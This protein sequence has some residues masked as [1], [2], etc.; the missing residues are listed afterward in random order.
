[1]S[2]LIRTIG[3]ISMIALFLTACD[4]KGDKD[5]PKEPK[6]TDT[7]DDT[8]EKFG[9]DV[10]KKLAVLDLPGYKRTVDGQMAAGS[11]GPW[12][13]TNQANPSGI[14]IQAMVT[15]GN[16]PFKCI[17]FSKEVFEQKKKQ[18]PEW[19]MMPK[20][21]R[22]N[23]KLVY[24]IGQAEVAGTKVLTVYVFSYVENTTASGTSR[25]GSH[26]LALYY[27]DGIRQLRVEM[28]GKGVFP[29]T[30]EELK[31]KITQ[32]ELMTS[33]SKVFEVFFKHF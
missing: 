2:G 11:V 27:N 28:S 33:G 6:K 7:K 19:M 10:L 21:H 29:K 30:E 26:H 31:T 24:E 22:E 4:D 12:Y 1:M 18:L 16:C 25:S 23:P 8:V 32:A 17:G 5:T 9:E 3:L 15:V 20:A 13:V 14:K